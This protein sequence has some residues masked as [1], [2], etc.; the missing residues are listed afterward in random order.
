MAIL[1]QSDRPAVLRA[2]VLLTGLAWTLPLLQPYHRFPLTGFYSE[3]LAL[4]LGLAA[5]APLLLRDS[6]RDAT[7]PLIAAAPLALAVVLAV[8]VALDRVPYPE[9]ALVGGLYLLWAALMALLGHAL[10]RRLTLDSIARALAW[11]LLAGGL[12]H[13]LIGLV[14][15]F[16]VA[17]PFSFLI[18]RKGWG[19]IYGNLGQP[20]HYAA[21]VT[22]SLASAAYLYSR[23]ALPVVVAALCAALFLAVLAL[24]GSRSP[25]LYLVALVALAL[26]LHRRQRDGSSRRL[27]F[28]ACWLLPGF[29]AADWLV[30]L[31]FLMPEEGRVVLTSAESL[32]QYATGVKP[33]LQLWGEAWQ[34]FLAA[35]VLGA[36]FGQFAWHHFLH[37]A[38]SGE[39][40]A[41]GLFNHS[42]NVVF[43]LLAETGIAGALVVAGAVAAWIADLR[44]VKLDPAWWWL[45][46]LLAVIGIHSLLEYPLWY[47]YF[48]GPAA[49]LLG[50]GAQRSLAVRFPGAARAAA[51]LAVLAGCVNLAAV[52]P[53]YRDFEQLVF[54]AGP[55]AAQ[56]PSD[57]AFAEALMRVHGEPLLRPYVE[58]AIAYGVKVDREQLN[59]KLDLVARAVHFVPVEIL[60]YR[61]ALLLALA[62]RGEAAR[63]QLVRSLRAYPGERA[64]AIAELDEL[65]VRYPSELKPL[66]ELAASKN[67]K[68]R[69]SRE[70]K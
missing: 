7:V 25:W 19:V 69:G 16:N 28:F 55:R 32:F 24:S 11:C 63:E 27:A 4:A 35:P 46:A 29:V 61:Q 40:A 33:R 54:R 21:T 51:A 57:A 20:N 12:L 23:G 37:L 58:L 14:Q 10:G 47:S 8:Q 42:H 30:T 56:P 65:A 67:T 62:G 13:V 22:L 66:L 48:L 3:W 15:H 43:Q 45:L 9:T 60:V 70:G 38:A 64:A 31:P 2:A 6:W 49:F 53:A 18:A 34:M 44:R 68:G 36:G 17:T 1:D 50:L 26:L 41:P 59:D 39:S 52:I 5:A